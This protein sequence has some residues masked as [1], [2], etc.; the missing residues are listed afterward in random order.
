MPGGIDVPVAVKPTRIERCAH[1][2]GA[3]I[4]ANAFGNSVE[5]AS[6]AGMTRESLHRV[7]KKYGVRCDHYRSEG[8]GAQA[9]DGG[10]PEWVS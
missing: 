5:A 8:Q 2:A 4:A 6:Q 3:E 9:A 1:A 7:L 10:G